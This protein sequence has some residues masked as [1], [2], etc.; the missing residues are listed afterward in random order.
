MGKVLQESSVQVATV[1]MRK[2]DIPVRAVDFPESQS[3]SVAVSRLRPKT[4]FSTAGV[5]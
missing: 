3:K 5:R 4:R 2:Q 1:Q